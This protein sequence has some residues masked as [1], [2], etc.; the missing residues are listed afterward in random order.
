VDWGGHVTSFFPEVVPGIHANPEHKITL[1]HA[2]TTASSSSAMLKQAQL[3]TLVTT[4]SIRTTRRTWCV[5]SRRD[6]TSQ[7]DF[8]INTALVNSENETVSSLWLR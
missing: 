8:G 5:M 4:R 6:V 7:V 1:V 2:G 3:D